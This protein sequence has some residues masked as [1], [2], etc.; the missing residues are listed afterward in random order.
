MR[1]LLILQ[2]MISLQGKYTADKFWTTWDWIS[3]LLRQFSDTQN[4]PCKPLH[5][6][7]WFFAESQHW[8]VW[9]Y[10]ETT[11]GLCVVASSYLQWPTTALWPCSWSPLTSFCFCNFSPC[12][13]P[14][15]IEFYI[16]MDLL[17][18][19]SVCSACFPSDPQAFFYNLPVGEPTAQ[20][21]RLING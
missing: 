12:N 10:V 19:L 15:E 18:V 21:K 5:Q 16:R 6:F 17:R 20:I 1:V 3:N 7:A 9:I 13:S 2:Q 14:T 11:W 4:S 8:T